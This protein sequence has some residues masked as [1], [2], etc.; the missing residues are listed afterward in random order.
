MIKDIQN[1]FEQQE[2]DYYKTLRWGNFIAI[3]I[4]NINLTLIKIKPHQ[5]RNNLFKLSHTWKT[6]WIISK[7]L[8][9]GKFDR[10]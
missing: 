9:H 4:L 2:E 3:I 6:S 8:I 1:L 10:N 7:N 5:S